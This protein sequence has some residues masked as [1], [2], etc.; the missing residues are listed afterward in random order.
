MEAAPS[1]TLVVWLHTSY[2]TNH[3]RYC[4][5]SEDELISNVLLHLSMPVLTDQQKLL[6]EHWIS[7]RGVSLSDSW[8]RQIR[9]KVICG[10]R[11]PWWWT[12]NEVNF[13]YHSKDVKLC[14]VFLCEVPSDFLLRKRI[15][16]IQ[17]I[18][19]GFAKMVLT[20]FGISVRDEYQLLSVKARGILIP[21]EITYLFESLAF[22]A[23]CW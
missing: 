16:F 2:L 5:I 23:S 12:K 21:C 7:S 13:G 17:N 10:I 11:T 8:L 4:W 14:Y 1:K 15:S 6:S 20:K 18:E 9:D 3:S 22:G 19:N